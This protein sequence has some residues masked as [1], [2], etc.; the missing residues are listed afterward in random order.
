MLV[1]WIWFSRIPE[2]FHKEKQ[3]L[4][5][6]FHDPEELYYCREKA[7]PQ[8]PEKLTAYLEEKDLN[9]A[10]AILDACG[11]KN[12]G[13]LTFGDGAYPVSYTHLTLPTKA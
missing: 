11:K 12:V 13:I 8:L 6:H 7:L 4:L 9:E 2:Q 10:Q 1:H 3:I 5:Q